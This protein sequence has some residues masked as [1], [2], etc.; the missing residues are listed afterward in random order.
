VEDLDDLDTSLT[1]A[2]AQRFGALLM[3]EAEQ[4]VLGADVPV[5]K[6][7]GL[8]ASELRDTAEIRARRPRAYPGDINVKA[9]QRHDGH[10]LVQAG[11]AHQEVIG[12]DPVVA[13]SAGFLRRQAQRLPCTI[14]QETLQRLMKG[15]PLQALQH[16]VPI[17]GERLVT[18]MR[19]GNV[20]TTPA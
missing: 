11:Q 17:R 1:K 6:S 16:G 18:S 2:D 14:R 3:D 5:P 4:Q 19:D 9:A 7:D 20:S 15:R 12:S 13:T 8:M 10:A